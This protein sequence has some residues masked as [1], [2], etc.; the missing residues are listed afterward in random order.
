MMG[1]ALKEHARAHYRDFGERLREVRRILSISEQEAAAMAK[2]T[3]RTWRKWEAGGRIRRSY[4]WLVDFASKYD[5]SYLWLLEGAGPMAQ[6]EYNALYEE[7]K[8]RLS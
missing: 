3:V 1:E 2:V 4:V 6:S 5:L 8:K 7:F